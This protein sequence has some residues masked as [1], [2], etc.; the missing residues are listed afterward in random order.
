M[1]RGQPEQ[2]AQRF[3]SQW[4][5]EVLAHVNDRGPDSKRG[6]GA[7]RGFQDLARHCRAVV[8]RDALD[9]FWF[10]FRT[11]SCAVSKDSHTSNGMWRTEM[12]LEN[13]GDRSAQTQLGF[14]IGRD[15]ARRCSSMEAFVDTIMNQ[16]THLVPDPRYF[17]D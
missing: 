11:N 2:R 16:R 7:T 10:V 14:W 4:R 3:H 6:H 13:K 12:L 8:V 15:N 9:G 1:R 17:A 5:A